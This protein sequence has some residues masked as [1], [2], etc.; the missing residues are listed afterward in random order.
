MFRTIARSVLTALPV[1]ALS[2][3]ALAQT[4]APQPAAAGRPSFYQMML[5]KM[6]TNGDGRISLDEYVAAATARFKAADTQN[7]GALDAADIATA[8]ATLNRDQKI[9]EFVVKHLDTDGKGYFTKD[10]VV[11]RAKQRFA[12]MDKKGDGKLTPDELTA[13]GLRG[14]AHAAVTSSTDVSNKRAEFRQKYFDKIDANHDGVITLDEYVAAASAR[15]DKI[16]TNGSGEVTAQQVAASPRMAK[17]EQ[18][19]AAHEVKK[20]DSD[21]DGTVSQAEYIAAARARFV[22]LDKNGD[23]FIDADEMPARHWAHTRNTGDGG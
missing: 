1:T 7:K 22:K 19:A 13:F 17:G 3:C 4:A 2:V 8:P 11:A 15:F 5:Q 16:D 18:R 6:D 14:H 23:G 20:M 10:D 21:G 12:K 9:A